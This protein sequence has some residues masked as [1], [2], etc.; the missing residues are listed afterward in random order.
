MSLQLL[1]PSFKIDAV[2]LLDEGVFRFQRP[3]SELLGLDFE[4]PILT[5]QLVLQRRRRSAGR[6]LDADK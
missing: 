1:H 6:R 2:Q 5:M 3:S 4:R